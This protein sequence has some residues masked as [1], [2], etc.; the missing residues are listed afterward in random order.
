MANDAQKVSKTHAGETTTS[1]DSVA[2]ETSELPDQKLAA[3]AT[4]FADDESV[5]NRPI[6]KP[7][8]G[9]IGSSACLECHPNEHD[10]WSQSYHRTMTQV[11]SPDSVAGGFEGNSQE[12]YGW[13]FT[14]QKRGDEYWGSIKSMSGDAY[15]EYQLVMSTGS[16]H[17]QKY[18]Y[19]TG[20]SRKMGMLPMVYLIEAD[21]WLPEKSAFLSPPQNSLGMRE[22]AWNTGC[23]QCH[24]TGSHPRITGANEMDTLV[25]EFGISCEACHGPGET[26]AQ[27]K[28]TS[29]IVNPRELTALKSAQVCGQCHGAW[30]RTNK[31][32]SSSW[33]QTGTTYRPGDDLFATRYYPHG[34]KDKPLH[35]KLRAVESFW[36][37]GENRVAGREMNGLLASPCHAHA[38]GDDKKMSCISC[39][40]LHTS[41]EDKKS[42]AN[43]QM[44][45]GMYGNEACLQCHETYREKLVEHTHHSADSSGSLC[46]NCHM[47]YTSYGLL[48]AVRTH[49]VGSPSAQTTVDTGKINACN[50]CHLD[51]TLDWTAQNLTAMYGHAEVE[52]PTDHKNIAAS[53][54]WTAKGDAAQRALMAWS[55]GWE[56]AREVSGDSWTVFYLVDLMFDDYDAIRY[57]AY[58]SLK[59]IP[60]FES[61]KYD[62]MRPAEERERVTNE[63]LAAWHASAQ[64]RPT[65]AKLLYDVDGEIE[66]SNYQSLRQLRDTR[67]ILVTE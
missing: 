31:E 25:A 23:N 62:H 39:H 47:P 16:H 1:D 22:G 58:R 17:M 61:I 34:S 64:E 48:K 10:S 7:H 54:V 42:W 56:D 35:E 3:R 8:D 66:Y 6:Q 53:V 12:I 38:L 36:P 27:E 26:H 33:S 44:G 14:P 9:Y 49:T 40:D 55:M 51:Q 21:K 2:S 24:A 43:D 18:W 15:H 4:N 29:S 46:Y 30:L 41:A 65:D 28:T 63:V 5:S 32:A 19:H 50:Q 37:D 59:T 11:V 45:E 60:G 52:L 20:K 13:E 57:I 67:P